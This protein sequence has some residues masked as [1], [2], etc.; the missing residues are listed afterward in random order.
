VTPKQAEHGATERPGFLPRR[1]TAAGISARAP[2]ATDLDGFVTFLRSEAGRR[3]RTISAYVADVIAFVAFLASRE[4]V[5]AAP[6]TADVIGAG[7]E[8]LRSYLAA[9]LKS[10]SRSTVSRN[11]ASLRAFYS[12]LARDGAD[13]GGAQ[14]LTAP[15]VPARLPVYLPEDDMALLLG[16]FPASSH[17]STDPSPADKGTNLR[18][19]ALL[20][21]LYSCGL[22]SS[23][24]VSLDWDHV[25]ANV[26]VV[27]VIRGKGGKQRVVPIG[28]QAL[29]ALDAYRNGWRH[30]RLDE[31]A[32]FLNVRGRRL[33][34]RS[35]GRIVERAVVDSGVQ[36]KAS[37]HSLRH[38]FAT[39]LLEHGADLRA[40]QEML[41]HASISTTQKYTHLDLRRLSSV[42]AKSHPRS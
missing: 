19:R 7:P 41:G 39:H 29:Q 18:N 21:V 28:G 32:V 17:D 22:R 20:E 36:I 23:E 15:K 9:R 6:S 34:S 37:P 31:K 13:D 12:Y 10:S 4:L 24:C 33:T 40:I 11:L 3:E 25:D 27:R 35:V 1:L 5:S 38:S 2:L 42:Y 26:G 30:V 14:I 8:G 16:A